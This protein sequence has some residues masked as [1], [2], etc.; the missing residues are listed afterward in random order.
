[1]RVTRFLIPIVPTLLLLIVPI[2]AHADFQAGLAAYDQ[3]DYATALSEFLPL[4]QQGDVKAQFNMGILYEKGQG[5]PQDF[6]EAFRWYY[7]AAAQGD[8]STQ[9]VLGMLYEYGQGVPQDYPQA[10]YWYG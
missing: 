5:V 2:P 1:M 6:Q 7:L 4:A 8:A 3:G 9:N 10:L